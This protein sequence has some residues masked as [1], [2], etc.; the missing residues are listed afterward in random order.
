MRRAIGS[1]A[2]DKRGPKVN[3]SQIVK[4]RDEL[5]FPVTTASAKGRTSHVA[6]TYP[7]ATTD[8]PRVK[9]SLASPVSFY[10]VMRSTK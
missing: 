3:A 8:L 9:N 7:K 5:T 10:V 4:V 1:H 2:R 6:E